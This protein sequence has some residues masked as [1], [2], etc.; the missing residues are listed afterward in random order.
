MGMSEKRRAGRF[1]DW[2]DAWSGGGKERGVRGHWHKPGRGE[3]LPLAEKDVG[4][5]L[6]GRRLACF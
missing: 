4:R 3:D 1:L 6:G 5:G 2:K